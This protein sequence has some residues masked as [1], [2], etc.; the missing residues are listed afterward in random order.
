ML[1]VK[2]LLL[3]SAHARDLWTV[4]K[5][6]C[7]ALLLLAI[8]VPR[9][10]AQSVPPPPQGAQTDAAFADSFNSNHVTNVFATTQKTSCYTPTVPYPANLAPP[11]GTTGNTPSTG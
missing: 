2:P 7:P 5:R 9:S 6:F 10:V 4:P 1:P 8:L 3:H 11:N